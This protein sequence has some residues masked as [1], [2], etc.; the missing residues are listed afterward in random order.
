MKSVLLALTLALGTA[1]FANNQRWNSD[2]PTNEPQQPATVQ[3]ADFDA[4]IE[5]EKTE[6]EVRGGFTLGPTSN[7]INLFKEDVTFA[8]GPFTKTIPAGA[9]KEEK[10]GKI[11][12]SEATKNLVLDVTIKIVGNNKF[13]V[14]IEGENPI[15][16]KNV[17]PEEITLK[18]GDDEGRARERVKVEKEN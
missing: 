3:F 15:V 12:Y 6:F 7:G 4:Q 16:T 8:V 10:R 18:I 9:F 14:K 2:A 11:S 1:M 13:T 17:R 5:V